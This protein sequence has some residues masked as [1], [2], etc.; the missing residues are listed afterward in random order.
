MLD[1]ALEIPVDFELRFYNSFSVV[2]PHFPNTIS[3]KK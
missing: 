3:N 2:K 1:I